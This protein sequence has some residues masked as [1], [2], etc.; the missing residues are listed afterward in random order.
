MKEGLIRLTDER[1][2]FY[3]SIEKVYRYRM[4]CP[5]CGITIK[6]CMCYHDLDRLLDDIDEGIADYTCSAKCALFLGEWDELGEAKQ[7]AGFGFHQNIQK[8][9]EKG[10]KRILEILTENADFDYPGGE[11]CEY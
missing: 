3:D 4:H 10:C 6:N 2:I 7:A 5:N 1:D 11:S 9:S 8:I